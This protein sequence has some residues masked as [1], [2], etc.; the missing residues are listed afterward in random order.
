MGQRGGPFKLIVNDS[1]TDN[2]MMRSHQLGK[3]IEK[4]EERR[5][6]DAKEN[7]AKKGKKYSQDT[8][9]Y[10][11]TLAEINKSFTV[12][13]YSFFKPFVACANEYVLHKPTSGSAQ[14]GGSTVF[15]LEQVGMFVTDMVWHVTASSFAAV[16]SQDKVRWCALPGFRIGEHHNFRI[17]GK[18]IDEYYT[19]DYLAKYENELDSGRKAMW[20]RAIG[21]QPVY[22]GS[23]TADPSNDQFCQ[24]VLVT[25]GAQ[26]FKNTQPALDMWVP[27][28]LWFCDPGYALPNGILGHGS[29]ELE[30]KI[31][32]VNDMISVSTNP[33][34]SGQYSVPTI[35]TCELYVNNLSVVPEVMDIFEAKV[36]LMLI[37]VHIHQKEIIQKARGDIRLIQLRYPVERFFFA[38]R[39]RDNL[40]NSQHWYKPCI[41]TET[42][43]QVPV[44]V[45]SSGT[46]TLA[47]NVIQFYSETPTVNTLSLTAN[48]IPLYPEMPEAF[49]NKYI[50]LQ[51]GNAD[52]S[53]PSSLGWYTVNFNTKPFQ[54][55][56][57]WKPPSGYFNISKSRELILSYSSSYINQTNDVDLLMSATAINF[58][59]IRDSNAT[60]KLF[61]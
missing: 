33:G 49:F 51:A 17:A 47:G 18:M 34:G 12:P 4:I 27:S 41:L 52:M 10:V 5:E 59:D 37:R 35:V 28:L 21:Q 24:T 13:I 14:F 23:L 31:A 3:L 38:F 30:I 43:V 32:N 42:D 55:R 61:A 46:P 8:Q 50:G 45:L 16:S 15:T 2:I 56:D 22:Q 54:N 40:D 26:T 53:A 57:G 58:L 20:S 29:V 36:A 44:V 9:S 19:E 48:T 1:E 60:R 11:P 7:A 39:P 25:N 6:I